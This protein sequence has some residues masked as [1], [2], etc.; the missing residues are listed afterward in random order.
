M[1]LSGPLFQQNAPRSERP[2]LLVH[3][4]PAR[5]SPA[6]IAAEREKQAIADKFARLGAT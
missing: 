5:P 4:L 2:G 6:Q 3:V 1:A